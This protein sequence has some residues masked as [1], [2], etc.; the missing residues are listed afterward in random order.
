MDG[1]HIEVS[2]IIN[3]TLPTVYAILAD[4]NKGHQRILPKRYFKKM[5]VLEG[6]CGGG[7]RIK[8]E[9]SVLGKKSTLNFLVSEPEPGRILVE[10]DS[11][12]GVTTRFTLEPTGDRQT[13]VT[14]DSTMAV[15]Q[16][17]LG[18][19]ERLFNKW[20]IRRIYNE[21]LKMLDTYAGALTTTRRSGDVVVKGVSN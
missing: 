5:S 10:T 21:E 2:K 20:L 7:T 3:A 9:M 14:I 1:L 13:Q 19:L 17:L 18:G 16:G 12:A 4:Y 11:N 15:N 8:V 6:G